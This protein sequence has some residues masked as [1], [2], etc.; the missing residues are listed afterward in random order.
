MSAPANLYRI[1]CIGGSE[2]DFTPAIRHLWGITG[3]ARWMFIAPNDPDLSKKLADA[4]F[5]FIVEQLDGIPLID[6]FIK[7]N[8]L[9][10][11]NELALVRRSNNSRR[12]P[13]LAGDRLKI[14]RA[15]S[16][17]L[18]D[19]VAALPFPKPSIQLNWLETDLAAVNFR[20]EFEAGIYLPPIVQKFFP[21]ER[22]VS[23][24]S[25]GEGW[26]GDPLV[27]ILPE[28]QAVT[29]FLKF[30]S[31]KR[32]FLREWNGHQ[33]AR[34]W[35][36]E[37]TVDLVRI[38]DLQDSPEAHAETFN[39]AFV[40]CYRGADVTTTLKRLY[41]DRNE[42]FI[43]RAYDQVI[44]VLSKNQP[45]KAAKSILANEPDFGPP[46]GTAA[47]TSMLN[48]LRTGKLAASILSSVSDF[49]RY[50]NALQL[51]CHCDWTRVVAR[52]QSFLHDETPPV[53]NEFIQVC[54]GHI[55]GDANSRNFLFD[56]RA[57]DPDAVVIV[58]WGGYQSDG[59]RVF[60]LAQLES[61]L[62]FVL[63]ATE[64]NCSG[65]KD[66]DTARLPLWIEEEHRSV[67][68]GLEFTGSASSD[69]ATKRAY[70]IVARIRGA[71]R[72]LSLGDFSGYA[73]F[74]CL[75]YWT[76]RKIRHE[77]LPGAKRLLAMYSCAM[78]I[79]KLHEW[80]RR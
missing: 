49:E 65:L 78:L 1:L 21:E 30:F 27:R 23:L 57:S 12:L 47:Q 71:A 31:D 10:Q 77:R 22:R 52:I 55:G 67:L 24:I 58:D 48:S 34:H 50:G 20:Q 26:S 79:H 66:L 37:H 13:P 76:L 25:V 73:Y 33:R 5:V 56:G 28:H 63:M 29:H 7:L 41:A 80:S 53:L 46:I 2:A 19:L 36:P 16:Q 75:L 43:L 9:K 17:E 32:A 4:N 51:P 74:F 3:L 18:I 59:L 6:L 54:R 11:E 60:D 38:I 42:R 44:T 8:A 45:V 61:D 70:D 15:N 64:Q 62:K 40:I 68:A 14:V 72:F 69:V 35:L 39:G